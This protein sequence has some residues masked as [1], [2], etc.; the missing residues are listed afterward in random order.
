M[1]FRSNPVT[2]E[3]V[4]TGA[5]AA[6]GARVS[7]NGRPEFG[8]TLADDDGAFAL[9]LNGGGEIVLNVSLDGHA[10][11]QRTVPTGWSDYG[12]LEDIVLT[13]LDEPT[14]VTLGGVG[15]AAAGDAIQ[16]VPG[17]KESDDDGQRQ[18]T[19][20]V[21]P[22]TD[23]TVVAADGARSPLTGSVGIRATELTVGAT[24]DTAMPGS[25]PPTSGYTYA[26]EYSIDEAGNAKSV[27]F[28]QPVISY[29]DN[30]IDA[31]EIGRAHV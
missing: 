20:L 17:S 14:S 8:Y 30:F 13:P 23:A 15:V 25:L 27:E 3:R 1:L 9:A 31:P 24:G 21:K 5:T 29:T 11:V 7:V 26:V 10:P 6:A 4:V 18:A 12:V 2:G 19:L 16:V 28:D 22:G